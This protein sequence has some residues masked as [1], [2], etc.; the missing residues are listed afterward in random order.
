VLGDNG[1]TIEALMVHRLGFR[2]DHV[3]GVVGAFV[4]GFGLLR[5]THVIVHML[6]FVLQSLIYLQVMFLCRLIL[7]P[8]VTILSRIAFSCFLHDR[9]ITILEFERRK[10][11]SSSTKLVGPSSSYVLLEGVR[12]LRT[13]RTCRGK[14]AASAALR[15]KLRQ[16]TKFITAPYHQPTY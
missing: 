9:A 6:E 3:N 7:S 8:R 14:R 5:D 16:H 15:S 13:L 4:S 10:G 11:Q 1:E 2:H 12:T